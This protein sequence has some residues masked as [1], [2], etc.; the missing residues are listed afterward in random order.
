MT[1]NLLSL[2][3]FSSTLLFPAPLSP[4]LCYLSLQ[5]MLVPAVLKQPPAL[6]AW[7]LEAGPG[8]L[9]AL[10]LQRQAIS[11]ARHLVEHAH[12]HMNMNMKTDRQTDRQTER[13]TDTIHLCMV[14]GKMD[15]WLIAGCTGEWLI[16]VW[17][18]DE[19]L[20]DEWLIDGWLID[21][22]LIDRMV[23]L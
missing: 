16:D 3:P 9:I 4:S 8:Q 5:W 20:I 22:W 18:I 10:K 6:G 17:L 21:G 19:W 13:K 14:N 2:T 23:N 1:P 11:Q 7:L 12:R 15:G